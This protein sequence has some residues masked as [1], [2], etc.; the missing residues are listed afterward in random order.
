[1]GAVSLPHLSTVAESRGLC[2]PGG[3][4]IKYRVLL[5]FMLGKHGNPI[6]LHSPVSELLYN[7]QGFQGNHNTQQEAC[8]VELSCQIMK[9][10]GSLFMPQTSSQSNQ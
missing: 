8:I 1:M 9:S 4:G 6:Y 5:L 2:K 7:S 3:S 10:S